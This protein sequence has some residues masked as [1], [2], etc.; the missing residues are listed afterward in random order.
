MRLLFCCLHAPAYVR[1]SVLGGQVVATA[2]QLPLFAAE[3]ILV[4]LFSVGLSLPEGRGPLNRNWERYGLFA[5]FGALMLFAAGATSLFAA[6]TYTL[7][8]RGHIALTT[9]AGARPTFD[10]VARML[11]W[12]FAQGLPALDA[13][14]TLRWPPPLSYRDSGTGFILLSYKALIIVPLIAAGLAFWTST[15]SSRPRY[16]A[17]PPSL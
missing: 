10:Q 11:V 2:I 6:I 4:G 8:Q 17:V 7:A 9:Y 12:T 5:P 3:A 13:T 16:G 14:T 15:K 1:P